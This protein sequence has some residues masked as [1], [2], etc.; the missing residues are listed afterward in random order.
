MC[1]SCFLG[2]S[3]SS[4]VCSPFWAVSYQDAMGNFQYIPC[5]SIL[6]PQTVM[7]GAL[8]LLNNSA[9][10]VSILHQNLMVSMSECTIAFFPI[11]ETTLGVHH[12]ASYI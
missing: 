1:P 9:V 10:K 12:P 6:Q 11:P 2:S 8:L 4:S 7:N 5:H 3:R